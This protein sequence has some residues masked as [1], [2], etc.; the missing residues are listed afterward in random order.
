MGGACHAAGLSFAA[1]H[2]SYWTHAGSVERMN[3]ILRDAFVELHS[4][5]LLQQLLDQFKQRY[6]C[7]DPDPQ[8]GA[9]C[10]HAAVSGPCPVEGCCRVNWSAP[11]LARPVRA[12]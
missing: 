5:D 10:Q 2:D 4:P 11:E 8:T 3:M 6:S 9:P 1:V 7:A 12:S